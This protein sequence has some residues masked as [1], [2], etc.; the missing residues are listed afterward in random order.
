VRL[1]FPLRCEHKLENKEN[2]RKD[3]IYKCGSEQSVDSFDLVESRPPSGEGDIPHPGVR[4][5]EGRIASAEQNA[6]VPTAH[7]SVE[8]QIA[9]V[10][11]GAP[12]FHQVL[13]VL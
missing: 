12:R 1:K 10:Y 7:R 5:Q 13:H 2:S 11:V 8:Y 9:L 3:T 6:R 4:P